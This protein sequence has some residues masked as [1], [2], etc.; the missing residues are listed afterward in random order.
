[1]DIVIAAIGRQKPSPEL[2]LIN[3][4]VRQTRW[5]I[6]IR[7]FEDKKPG[8]VEERKQREGE[9]LLSAVP[10]GAVIIA[11]DERGR[12][13]GSAEFARQIGKWQDSGCPAAA[14]LIGGA[15][16]HGD[17]IRRR[18]DML[19]AFGAMTWPHM[20]ARVMLTEQIY[21]ARTILDGHPYHRV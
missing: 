1:M 3:R 12:T 4:Y 2:D 18:A 21:R 13:P 6:T 9:M 20:L 5:K 19:L 11:L 10:P 17:G 15:D 8:T 16:G 7:E 14:F